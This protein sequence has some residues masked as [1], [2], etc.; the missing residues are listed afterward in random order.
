MVYH[1]QSIFAIKKVK[2]S[3]ENTYLISVQFSTNISSLF[4][5]NTNNFKL[6]LNF[7]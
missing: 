6:V 7:N 1:L 5:K 4:P 2:A 3:K